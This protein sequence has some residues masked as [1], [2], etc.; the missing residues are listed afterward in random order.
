VT[1]TVVRP[2]TKPTWL[3][4]RR[5]STRLLLL[6]TVLVVLGVLS[7]AFAF[8]SAVGREGMVAVARPVANGAV[9]AAEDVRE[10][11][12][13]SASGLTGVPWS[14]AGSVVGR[15]AAVDLLPGQ[16][17]TPESVTTDRVP[18][19]GEAVVG[20]SV[21]PGRVPSGDLAR[22]DPVLIVIEPG[23]P[24]RALVVRS[25]PPGANGRRDVDVL[26]SES[27]AVRLAAASAAGLTTVVAVGRS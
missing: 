16:V 24:V 11:L 9:V 6:G 1:A 5:R 17:V 2:P 13:P 19:P 25:G 26:V 12:L 14:E 21:D 27:D 22:R 8:R 3:P 4:R 18:R 23:P 20:L 15:F 7:G 10:V